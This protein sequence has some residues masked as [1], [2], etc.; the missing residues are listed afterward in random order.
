[1]EPRSFASA[2]NVPPSAAPRAVAGISRNSAAVVPYAMLFDGTDVTIPWA[3]PAVLTAA[4]ATSTAAP[5]LKE[6]FLMPASARAGARRPRP[7]PVRLL[8]EVDHGEPPD[9]LAAVGRL[10]VIE[11]HAAGHELIVPVAEVPHLFT[12]A[13]RVVVRQQVHQDPAHAVDPDDRLTGQVD[14]PQHLGR[15]RELELV[16]HVVRI[17]H[18]VHPRQ[19]GIGRDPRIERRSRVAELHPEARYGRRTRAGDERIRARRPG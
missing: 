2:A 15:R 7:S 14:E 16:R 12:A 9:L 3:R 8:S 18:R 13:R 10:D 1:M 5:I 4:T 17:R 11:V 6:P 19:H